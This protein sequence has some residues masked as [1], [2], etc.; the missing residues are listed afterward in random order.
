MKKFQELK[1]FL[2]LLFFAG[3]VI[4]VFYYPIVMLDWQSDI[5]L[6]LII[7]LWL[8]IVKVSHFSSRATFKISFGFLILLFVLLVFFSDHPGIER[9]AS[10][11]YV[12]LLIGIIQQVFE[13]KRK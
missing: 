12:F 5:R 13:S 2:L 8:F 11:I 6:F 4:D 1:I 3:F 7:S 10:W 9:I